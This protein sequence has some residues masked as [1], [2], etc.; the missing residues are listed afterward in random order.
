MVLTEMPRSTRDFSLADLRDPEEVAARFWTKVDLSD[1]TGCWLWT[2]RLFDGYGHMRVLLYQGPYQSGVHRVAVVLEGHTIPG[3]LT[4]DHLCRVR[5]CVNPSH[6]EV[7]TRRENTLRGEAPAAHQAKQTHCKRGH[8]LRGNNVYTEPG[9]P[10]TRKCRA[11]RKTSMRDW[12]LKRRN[13]I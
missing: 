9:R 5:H 1:P 10:N 2:G 4:V 7:V 3:D 11:C 8:E 6:L 13:L 12:Y